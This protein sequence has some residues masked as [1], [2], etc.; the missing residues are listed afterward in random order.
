MCE[1]TV[2]ETIGMVRQDVG[3]ILWAVSDFFGVG[4]GGRGVVGVFA[5][6]WVMF[7]MVGT[8]MQVIVAVGLSDVIVK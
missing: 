6:T 7:E 8:E 3:F 5:G 2:I 4:G 1:M